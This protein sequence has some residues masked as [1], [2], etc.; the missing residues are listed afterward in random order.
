MGFFTVQEI[1]D[2]TVV[3][4]TTAWLMD[5][6]ELDEVGE[7]LYRVVEGPDARQVVLDFAKVE[8]VSSQ[9]IGI[10]MNVHRKL[11]ELK[12]PKPVL[13][14][15]RPKLLQLLRITR[16]DRVLTIKPTRAEATQS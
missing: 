8:Y 11:T 15:L 4:F 10:I 9:A 6:R 16:L 1:G 3:E 5:A 13:C 14:G 12:K 7:Q 2:F